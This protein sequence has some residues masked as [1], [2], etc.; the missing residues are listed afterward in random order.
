MLYFWTIFFIILGISILLMIIGKLFLN[1]GNI[2]F[3]GIII[4]VVCFIVIV[5]SSDIYVKN[6]PSS[7]KPIAILRI[8][9]K[10]IVTDKNNVLFS[11]NIEMYK[12]PDSLICIFKIKKYNPFNKKVKEISTIGECE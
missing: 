10:I 3:V 12:L 1:N 8:K 7:Y 2:I 9:D 5:N 11:E 6:I 4:F